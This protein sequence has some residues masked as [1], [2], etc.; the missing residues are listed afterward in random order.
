M[1][2]TDLMRQLEALSLASRLRRVSD[3]MVEDV[4]ALY[5]ELGIQFNPRWF[6]YFYVLKDGEPYA[7]NDLAHLLRV[8][9]PTVIKFTNQMM[10]DGLLTSQ[11]DKQDRRRRLL[12]LT[13]KGRG[14]A[15]RMMP[16]WEKIRDAVNATVK[17]SGF[18]L[19]EGLN[20]FDEALDRCSIQDRYYQQ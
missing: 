14:L 10:K 18:Q 4:S 6:P 7:V 2:A 15:E 13:D 8:S 1:N 20:Q 12:T 19:F 9:H 5:T 3:R 16:V 11:I 17:D